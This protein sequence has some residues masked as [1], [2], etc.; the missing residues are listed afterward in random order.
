M[1]F[2]DWV[3]RRIFTTVH[4]NNLVYNTCWE[5]PRLDRVA[6]EFGPDDN[7]LVITSAG[8]NAL[9]YAL[10]GPNHVNAVDMNPRQNALLDL[11]M[12]AIRNLEFNDFFKMFGE[13]RLP[14][15]KNIY[16]QKL[17][18]SLPTWSQ[19]FWDKKIKWFD[20][21]RKS[22]YYR[23]TSGTIARM[24]GIYIDRVIRVR[25]QLDALLNADSVEEQKEIYEKHLKKKF[26]SGLM[27]FTMNRDTTMS[28][29]G[30]P[31]AQRRQIETQYEGG[32]VKFIQ[33]CMES[34]FVEL[35]MKDNYFWRVYMNG[36]YS[37]ECCPEY[38][39]EDNFAKLKGGV[40]DKVST[41][42]DSVQGFLE[43]TRRPNFALYPVGSY[44]L[45]Q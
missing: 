15:I 43:K 8:C 45:A 7:V 18:A 16:Q 14:G 10:A 21:R 39:K 11:K 4:G 38:L 40:V 34:V 22:F 2:L 30:V 36:A 37:R 33:D 41:N 25:P 13:G 19:S 20:N 42:T 31:K 27:K 3:N 32:L 12:S 29:L 5:D 17:R 28:M 6:L 9:D 24:I 44:G 35:P 26:W 23:G 1:A